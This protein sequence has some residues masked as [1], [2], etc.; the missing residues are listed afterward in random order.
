MTIELR[1]FAP[2]RADL[3][4]V[5]AIKYGDLRMAGWSPRMRSWFNYFSPDD[6]YETLVAKLVRED[7]FWLDVGSGRNVF[8]SNPALAEKLAQRCALLVGVDPDET[9]EEKRF[10]HEK[11]RT[12]IEELQTDRTF[13]LVTLRM[14]AEHVAQPELAVQSLAL[15]TKPR[16]KVVIYTI[17][18]WSP[19]SIVAKYTPM[20]VHHVAKR[21][22]WRTEEKDTFPVAYLMNTRQRLAGL[23]E[24]AG[25]RECFFT[26]LDD[27]RSFGRFRLLHCIELYTQSVLRKLGVRYHE[28]CLLGV[29]E[30]L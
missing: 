17:N 29:Y 5:L 13:D 28:N 2:T 27:C 20:K 24:S 15:L 12:S 19:A 3:D 4:E 26:Y 1:E 18:K 10:V 23:F 11:I 22:L 16:G 9:L 7:T 8:P 14:V 6:I 30:R 21:C 25:F